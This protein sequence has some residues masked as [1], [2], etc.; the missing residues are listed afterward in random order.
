MWG[1]GVLRLTEDKR[2][3]NF[4]PYKIPLNEMKSVIDLAKEKTVARLREEGLWNEKILLEAKVLSSVEAIGNPEEYDF[5]LLKGKERIVEANFNEHLGHAFT[6][7]YGG[8][9]GSLEEVFAMDSSNN[10]RRALQVATINALCKY[11]GLAE[12]TVHCRD[13]Q[14]K[15]CAGKCVK[16]VKK[17]Y[18][19]V[20][21]ITLIGYQ[22]ALVDAFSK[23]Y[24]LKV[25]D[26]DKDNIGEKKLGQTILDG[27][28]CLNGAIEWAQLVLSTG[29]TV[30]NGTIDGILN[31][32]GKEK[33]IFYGVTISG[34]AAILGLRRICFSS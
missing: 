18:P 1:R 9:Y 22:P 4:R 31:T 27:S 6:D 13:K 8:F 26:L 16:F 32:A 29:T 30:V 10:Y 14:P 23:K 12:D 17:N 25:L 11:W 20:E 2:S 7:M 24:M 33:V 3:L 19:T 15:I 21:R 28:T 5:P 34:I